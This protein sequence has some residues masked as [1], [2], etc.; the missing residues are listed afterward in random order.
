VTVT[1]TDFLDETVAVAVP[2]SGSVERAV[3]LRRRDAEAPTP[4]VVTPAPS[5]TASAPRA[6]RAAVSPSPRQKVQGVR[7]RVPRIKVNIVN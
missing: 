6:Q 4:A 2:P 7:E 1:R 3:T 5:S